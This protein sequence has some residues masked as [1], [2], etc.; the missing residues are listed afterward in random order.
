MGSGLR[1]KGSKQ[2]NNR[3]SRRRRP[4]GADSGDLRVKNLLLH[5]G[6]RRSPAAKAFSILTLTFSHV[7]KF[8]GG[9]LTDGWVK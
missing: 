3:S 9:S 6:K 4:G 8:S 1:S 2:V 5:L 7:K